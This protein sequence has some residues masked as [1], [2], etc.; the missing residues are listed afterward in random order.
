LTHR[1]ARGLGQA[2]LVITFAG[3]LIMGELLGP[4]SAGTAAPVPGEARSPGPS[5]PDWSAPHVANQLLV[6][7]SEGVK[8]GNILALHDGHVLRTIPQLGL[9]VVETPAQTDLS[10]AAADL[11]ELPGIEWAEPNYTFGL[12]YIPDDPYYA[13]YQAAYL[14]RLEMPLAWDYTPGRAEVVIAILDTGVDLAHEDL[15]DAIWINADEIANNGVDDDGNGFVDDVNGWDFADGDNMPTDDYGHGTHVAGIAAARIN[16]GKGIAGMAGNATV[17][18][19]DVFMGGI[20]TYEDLIRA[21]VYAADNGAD[22]INMSL[23]ASSYSLGEEAAV[24]YAWS[25]G[26]VLVAAAGNTGRNTYHY[27]AAHSHVIAVA[28]TDAGDHVASFSTHGDFVDVAAPGVS[29]Y[30]TYPRGYAAMSGTS[31][32]APHVSGLAALILSLDPN[33]SPDQVKAIIETTADDLG[34]PGWDPYFG[35]GRINARRALESVVPN[36]D[37]EPRSTPT[38]LAIWPAGCQELV[39]NGDFEDGTDSWQ[40]AGAV[41]IDATHPYSGSY[42]AHFP[43]GPASYGVLTE[44]VPLPPFPQQGTL[45][46]A[47]RIESQDTGW[48]SSPQS[49]YDDVFAVEFKDGDGR[50]ISSLLR[51][52]NSADTASSGLPW[53]RYLYRMQFADLAPVRAVSS[54]NL[55]F[56]AHNDGDT[57]PTNFWLDEVR[58][59]VTRGYGWIFP[60]VMK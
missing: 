29:V 49:P 4:T 23:G 42:A 36:P 28:A 1:F 32:A 54:V 60:T 58:W 24:E 13:L 9:A 6:G 15:Q 41:S 45:W 8:L 3:L 25:R 18:P 31:M 46:F 55:V 34:T 19:V 48:G 16:N 51:T 38:P 57:L 10:M 5:A 21:I 26:V 27:P 7:L 33:L 44:T 11:A 14:S 37:A 35:N 59:C 12:D 39:I 30:S 40:M 2:T 22:V 47:Y 43:G 56:T 53:D 20:G 17:M 50:V 52:G